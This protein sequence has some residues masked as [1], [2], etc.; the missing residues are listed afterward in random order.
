VIARRCG[1]MV[2]AF[3]LTLQSFSAL[4]ETTADEIAYLIDTIRHSS[5]TFI[6]NDKEYD[7]AAAADHITAKYQ[8]FKPQIRTTE[9]FI[10]R[11]ATKSEMTGEPYRLRCDGAPVMNAADWLRTTLA[12]HRKDAMPGSN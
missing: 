7:A 5:C 6:R 3:S 4:A 9:D 11:A 2:M 10:D 12:T 8:H 1:A